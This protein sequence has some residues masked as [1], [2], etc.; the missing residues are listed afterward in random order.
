MYAAEAATAAEAHELP[1]LM[2]WAAD[3][4]LDLFAAMIGAATWKLAEHGEL[5]AWQPT[6]R[7]ALDS[8]IDDP[9]ARAILLMVGA[10]ERRV[11]D[12]S[13]AVEAAHEGGDRL[14][15]AGLTVMQLF[16]ESQFFVDFEP[17][18]FERARATLDEFATD[19]DPPRSKRS[20]GTPR[21]TCTLR[22][23]ASRRRPPRSKHPRNVRRRG[24]G[25]RTSMWSATAGW[26][27]VASRMP[28]QATS[29]QLDKPTCAGT[30]QR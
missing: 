29:A 17:E 12:F 7:S 16:Y 3:N 9:L 18:W 20:L 11:P 23:G 2:A 15:A 28:W 10:R 26:R 30:R 14:L 6:V 13:P 5:Q 4:D 1:T 8:G 27:P 21:G 24:S 25:S 19:P 22:Q